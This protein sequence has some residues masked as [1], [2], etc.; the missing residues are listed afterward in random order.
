[1]PIGA[2]KDDVA[3]LPRCCKYASTA[4]YSSSVVVIT[5][6]SGGLGGPARWRESL[7]NKLVARTATTK[8]TVPATT[9]SFERWRRESHHAIMR[10]QAPSGEH[11]S[12]RTGG[13]MTCTTSG[14]A[15]EADVVKVLAGSCRVGSTK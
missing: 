8:L 5:S 9:N 11:D 4:W 7:S 12:D 14:V 15:N 3:L 6:G 1:V 13:D 10:V 2:N